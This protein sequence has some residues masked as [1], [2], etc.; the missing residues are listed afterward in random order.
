M[1][2]H[3]AQATQWALARVAV[4]RALHPYLLIDA[5]RPKSDKRPISNDWEVTP[6]DLVVCSFVKD[7]E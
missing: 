5:V 1:G 4:S 3:D 6:N 7:D 2:C